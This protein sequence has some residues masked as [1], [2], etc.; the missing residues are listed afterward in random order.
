MADVINTSTQRLTREQIAGIVGRNPRAIKLLENLL[1]DVTGTIPESIEQVALSMLS[2]LHSA[3]GSKNASQMALMIA[4]ETEA[5]RLTESRQ[6]SAIS[7]IQREVAEVRALLESVLRLSA[8]IS[9]LRREF[10]DLRA[11]TTGA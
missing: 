2:S 9:T 10:D 8:E 5:F 1:T 4:G 6:A 7:D 11:V 3:D